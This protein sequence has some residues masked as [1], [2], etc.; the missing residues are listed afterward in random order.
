MR[1]IFFKFGDYWTYFSFVYFF[2]FQNFV[3]EAKIPVVEFARRQQTACCVDKLV[4]PTS[5][6]FHDE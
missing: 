6:L 5:L 1:F 3:V 4:L 2:D